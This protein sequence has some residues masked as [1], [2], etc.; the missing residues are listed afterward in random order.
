MR[1]QAVKTREE[2]QYDITCNNRLHTS[3]ESVER[4]KSFHYANYIK[5]FSD[6]N[7]GFIYSK[8][9]NDGTWSFRWFADGKEAIDH[10]NGKTI[11]EIK[12]ARK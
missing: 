8:F 1:N 11:A 10:M 4:F 12:L 2:L 7:D 5:F 9:K 6:K 3:V